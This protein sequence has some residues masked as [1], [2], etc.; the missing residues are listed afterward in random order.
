MA[1]EI[2]Q[3]KATALW[4]AAPEKAELRDEDV[5]TPATGEV[6]VRALHGSLSRG[7]EALVFAGK[8]PQSEH[9][10]MRG[11]HMGGIFPFP[12][13]YGY[14]IVGRIEQGP[15][16]G[17]TVFALHPH[18][19]VFT[20]AADATIDVPADVP[21][22]RAVLAANM[23]TALNAMWDAAAGP[24]DRIAVVGAGVVGGLVAYLCSRLPGADVTLVDIDPS[25]GNLA[26]LLGLKF[27]LPKDAPVECDVVFHT[28]GNGAGLATALSL[29]GD[30]AKVIEMS[31]YGENEVTLP[32]GGAFHSRRL[33]IISSQVGRVAPSH[34]SRWPSARRLAAALA[35]LTDARL[36][37]LLTAP[38]QFADLPSQ[39]PRILAPGSGILCQVIDY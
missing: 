16:A 5:S 34:R 6:R 24:A 38:V 7:T 14:S 32:L 2:E 25:R 19:N 1:E 27:A 39:L 37:A 31:W 8:V 12:V 4:Y 28:S 26:A 30:E 33:Q 29:A 35:L 20:V 10:R 13:K 3:V 15:R 17:K 11:P 22:R 18:Q 21:P 23:E 9:R 36:D